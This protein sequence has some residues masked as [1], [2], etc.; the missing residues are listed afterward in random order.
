MMENGVTYVEPRQHN[1]PVSFAGT[2]LDEVDGASY[3]GSRPVTSTSSKGGRQ[4]TF[5]DYGERIKEIGRASCR[6]RV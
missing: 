2:G 6:E 1:R 5:R 3:L 4:L